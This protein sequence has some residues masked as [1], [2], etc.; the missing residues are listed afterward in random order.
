MDHVPND[1]IFQ[2]EINEREFLRYVQHLDLTALAVG[3]ITIRHL[4]RDVANLIAAL[5]HCSAVK[6]LE[7]DFQDLDQLCGHNVHS[8][9]VIT[10]FKRVRRKG[11]IRVSAHKTLRRFCQDPLDDLMGVL[12]YNTSCLVGS[13]N[14]C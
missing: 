2:S 6:N 14:A 11:I 1:Q 7:I 12:N 8:I 13:V 9:Q 3:S 4:S 10:A 5:D